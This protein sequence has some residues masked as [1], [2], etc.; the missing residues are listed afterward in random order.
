[1]LY[2]P[3]LMTIDLNWLPLLSFLISQIQSASTFVSC[4]WESSL[5]V[6]TTTASVFS[7]SMSSISWTKMQFLQ[8]YSS[9][10]SMVLFI[11]SFF[12]SSL[13]HLP[14]HYF[15]LFP[16]VISLQFI[17]KIFKPKFSFDLAMVNHLISF[18]NFLCFSLNTFH[19]TDKNMQ[20]LR[21]IQTF[22]KNII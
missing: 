19:I 10:L 3:N 6:Y 16:P 20:T 18:T 7:F 4:S 9:C 2:L 5:K 17:F 1:M 22:S 8:E 15:V 13:T 12:P 21:W 11:S 14:V